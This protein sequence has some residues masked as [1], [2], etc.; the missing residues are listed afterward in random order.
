M[1]KAFEPLEERRHH[2]TAHLQ[3]EHGQGEHEADPEDWDRHPDDGQHPGDIIWG[4]GWNDLRIIY[5]QG[6]FGGDGAYGEAKAAFDALVVD[7]M[8]PE[9]N[10]YE[11]LERAD[12]AGSHIPVI[13]CVGNEFED[14]GYPVASSLWAIANV[15]YIDTRE[16]IGCF[17]ECHGDNADIRAVF[18]GWKATHDAWDGHTD[19]IRGN[20]GQQLEK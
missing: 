9:L 14:A 5:G 1:G 7:I 17:L 18:N 3:Q 15:I 8:M 19:L 13:R 2:V 4:Q 6:R 12:W 20:R 10:G 16:A 11:V